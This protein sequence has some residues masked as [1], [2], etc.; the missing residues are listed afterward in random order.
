MSITADQDIVW[1]SYERLSRLK[2][3]KRK[4]QRHRGRY[5][6]PAE[7]VERQRRLNRAYAAERGL[8]LPDE[9]LYRDNGL[10]AW[11]PD[12]RRD[13]DWD[14]MLIDGKAGRFGGLLVWKLDRFA[15]NIR[16]GEDLI[17]LGV[18]VDG[19]DT[20][21][22]DLRTAH[23]KSVFRKQIEAATH[24]SNETSEK[25]RAAFADMLASGYRVG[26]SGRLFG[27][28]ILSLAEL[29]D[30]PGD[31]GEDGGFTLTGPAAV[32]REAEAEVIRELAGRLLGGETV[33]S[34]G[35]DLNARGITT[36]RGGRWEPRNLS[37]TLGNPLY[38]G[39]LAYKGEVITQL[40][41]VEAILDTETYNAVQAKLGARRLG[42]RVTGR[43]P[44]SGVA[45]CGNPACGRR[46]TMAGYTRTSGK[47]A[48]IC[49]V[50]NGGCGQSV[51][52]RPVEE[53]V[54]V[55]VLA[56][57]AD[58]EAL[59]AMRAADATLDAERAKLAGLL[60][61]LDA[62][63]AETEA[64]LRDTS[65][66]MTRRR[67]Q[68]DRNLAT[69]TARFGAVERELSDLGP[70]AAPAPPLI[71]ATAE[72]WADTP[73][74]E[75]AAIIRR[76]GLRITIVPPTRPQGSSRAPFDTARVQIR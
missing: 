17:D 9:L 48:Y 29:D 43:F 27:F 52:A 51:L 66:S 1:G 54:Q 38:G 28:E 15:R 22:L 5:R 3:S 6:D 53:L 37:R 63:L 75:Q 24:S 49:A 47:R 12:G 61:D 76:L 68:L 44:L 35:D 42:R 25:V 50:S 41:N 46:G 59:E 67:E 11:K 71:S 26:G 34:M 65:R 73:A 23:G 13:R 58:V 31:D 57:L 74:A 20:G 30:D 62:D 21:R 64:K 33:A 70:A 72:D 60:D 45:V 2:S 18:L 10:S 8:T 16:D 19:P 7:S 40:A 14:R 69:L 56:A 39:W 32:V 36:T 4:S 55:R